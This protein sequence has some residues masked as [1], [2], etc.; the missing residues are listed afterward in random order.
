[1]LI[2]YFVFNHP[3]TFNSTEVIFC[4]CFIILMGMISLITVL[5]LSR[6]NKKIASDAVLAK[7]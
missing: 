6:D 2:K 3:S 5:L 4:A 7:T 1:M